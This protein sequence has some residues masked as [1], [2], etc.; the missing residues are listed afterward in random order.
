MNTLVPSHIVLICFVAATLVVAGVGLLVRDVL[1]CFAPRRPKHLRL[2]RIA[3]VEENPGGV[4]ARF[5]NWFR[6]LV[7][8]CGADWSQS[9]GLLLVVLSG[10]AIGGGAW[11]FTDDIVAGCGYGGLG[12]LL[13]FPFLM[14]MQ[15]LHLARIQEQ[16]PNALD[17]LARAVRAGESVDQAISLCG[18][19][20]PEP[21]AKEFRRCARQL[22]MGL[23][24]PTAMRSLGRRVRIA[25]M[26]I[27]TAAVSVH[28]EAGGSLALTLDRMAHVVRERLTYRRQLRAV[29]AAGRFSATMVS[30]AGPLLFIYMFT[31]QN[32]Y[33]SRLL[34][35]PLGQGLLSLAIV[36]EL[37]G[38]IWVIRMQKAQ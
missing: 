23:A 31:F 36:L 29:T 4:F 13:P 33:V 9:T 25:D 16:L 30:L 37:V 3:V 7:L 27:F 18:H 20:G 35:Q 34:N 19:R 38:L 10:T 26:R 14:R 15:R 6:W 5:D 1:G 22:E 32:E 28:R 11:A 2:R 24:L 17:L 12:M 8:E 21:L